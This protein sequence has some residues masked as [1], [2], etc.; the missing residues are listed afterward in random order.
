M[1]NNEKLPYVSFYITYF[2]RHEC[3]VINL[4]SIFAWWHIASYLMIDNMRLLNKFIRFWS[5]HILILFSFQK[6]LSTAGDSLLVIGNR[7]Y[8]LVAGIILFVLFAP[9]EVYRTVL[10]KN[11]VPIVAKDQSV[12]MLQSGAASICSAWHISPLTCMCNK[13]VPQLSLKE[14][15]SHRTW[16]Q[17]DNFLSFT[18]FT[19]QL[20]SILS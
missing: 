14:I 12:A 19:Q 18:S 20:G 3:L 2:S 8:S 10:T 1:T 4:N 11:G 6:F 15:L 7:K 16:C 13:C 5:L 9:I 17:I